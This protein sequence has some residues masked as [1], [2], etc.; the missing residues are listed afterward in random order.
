M[1]PEFLYLSIKQIL[2]GNQPIIT[3]GVDLNSGPVNFISHSISLAIMIGSGMHTL[4][5]QNQ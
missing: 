5:Y 3:P 4:P 1:L 2:L